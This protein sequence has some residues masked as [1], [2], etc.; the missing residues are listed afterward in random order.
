MLSELELEGDFDKA[1]KD[2]DPETDKASLGAK[3]RRHYQLTGADDG[4]GENEARAEE[5]EF[6]R[7]AARGIE[8]PV[9]GELIGVFGHV[10]REIE[11]IA[12]FA[13]AQMRPSLTVTFKDGAQ[14]HYAEVRDMAGKVRMKTKV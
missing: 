10:R 5:A 3:E 13:E 14:T 9:G 1:G 11:Q 7:E 6:S 2:D 8:N 4:S 12:P